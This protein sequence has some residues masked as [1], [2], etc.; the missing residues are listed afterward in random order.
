MRFSERLLRAVFYLLYHPFAFTYD[1]VAA[2]VSLGRWNDWVGAVIP[3]VRGARVLELGHGPGHLQV[4]LRQL[5]FTVTGLDESN[6]MIRLASRRLMSGGYREAALTRG[7]ANRLPFPGNIFNSLVA[8]FPSDFISDPK[9]LEEARRVLVDGGRLIVLPV[10]WHIGRRFLERFLAWIF[11]VTGESPGPF[12]LIAKQVA[13]PIER[14]GFQ[15]ATH[16]LE[17][18]SSLLLVLVASKGD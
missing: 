15:V 14:N 12:E 1:L 16:K 18:Q 7:T 17:I 11:H 10:A 9:V 13:E 8:T 4:S 2:I 5:G 3:F 6:Q